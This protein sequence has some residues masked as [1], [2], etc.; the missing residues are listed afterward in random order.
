M[1]RRVTMDNIPLGADVPEAPWNMEENTPMKVKVVISLTL[2]K[3][4]YVY[5]DD[6]QKTEY[7][8]E[9]G[10]PCASY[11]FSDSD[12]KAAVVQQVNLPIGD[13]HVDDFEVV[14]DD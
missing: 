13:W 3:S 7:K 6:Y 9:D 1:Q 14:S 10:F 12:L 4:V 2:S 5:V 8:D 11:D